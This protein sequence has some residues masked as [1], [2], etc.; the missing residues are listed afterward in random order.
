MR[1]PPRTRLALTLADFHP[2]FVT[3]NIR[4]SFTADCWGAFEQVDQDFRTAQ[5]LTVAGG[6]SI[7][8]GRSVLHPHLDSF[9]A[10]WNFDHSP[11]VFPFEGAS[12]YS[13]RLTQIHSQGG[14]IAFQYVHP[15]GERPDAEYWIPREVLSRVNDKAFLGEL[16]PTDF[17]PARR[18]ME[19]RDFIE[20]ATNGNLTFQGNPRFVV[21]GTGDESSGGGRSVAIVRSAA[22]LRASVQRM[23]LSESVLVEELLEIQDNFNLT[24][25]TRGDE[26]LYLGASQQLTDASG[27]YLGNWFEKDRA[28]TKD[29]IEIGHAIMERATAW[30]YRGIAGF[31]FVRDVHGQVYVIDLNCR[32]NGSTPALLWI[33]A[34]RRRRH[35]S[36]VALFV[37]EKFVG[38]PEHWEAVLCEASRRMDL[39]LLGIQATR[40]FT[41]ASVIWLGADRA[42]VEAKRTAYRQ[43][44]FTSRRAA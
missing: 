4:R 36:S 20:S 6:M 5:C 44:L 32:I 40:G 1:R 25:A 42:E 43:K 28:P 16:V 24:Y 7:L 22:D 9:Y 37:R 13:D 12:E 14:Q 31:D 11:T 23:S 35:P 30:G 3:F 21:K 29:M 10:C 2:P 33:D 19:T 15:F 27:R 17:V 34:L 39:F 38:P 41:M 8:A 26:I 18:L